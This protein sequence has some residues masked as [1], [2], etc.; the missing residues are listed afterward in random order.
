M[1]T[2]YSWYLVIQLSYTTRVANHNEAKIFASRV[3]LRLPREIAYSFNPCYLNPIH[4]IRILGSTYY[5]Q[6]L[7]K[8]ISPLSR[9]LGTAVEVDRDRL[10]L[11]DSRLITITIF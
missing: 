8:K 7:H 11:T 4:C 9:S 6:S 10:S 3:Q 5:K 1:R 2:K